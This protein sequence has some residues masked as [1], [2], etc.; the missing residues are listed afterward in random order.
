MLEIFK[1]HEMTF[2]ALDHEYS[3]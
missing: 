1:V 3:I 2:G